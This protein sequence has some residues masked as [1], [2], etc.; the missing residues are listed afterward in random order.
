[1][2]DEVLGTTFQEA[3]LQQTTVVA[4]TSFPVTDLS[5]DLFLLVLM[6]FGTSVGTVATDSSCIYIKDAM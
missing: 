1:V 4:C 6:I 5:N 3:L 2:K